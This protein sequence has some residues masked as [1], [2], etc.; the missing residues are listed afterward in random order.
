MLITFLD[1]ISGF[2][3]RRF[4]LA[5]WAPMFI[6][7]GLA[8]G[9][10]AS[11]LGW[12]RVVHWWTLLSGV[13]QVTLAVTTLLAET[14]LAYVLQAVAVPLVQ[15]Y[16]GYVFW[17]T[18][19]AAW[20]KEDQRRLRQ[21]L[22]DTQPQVSY[23][24]FPRG[25]DVMPTGLGNVFAAAEDYPRRMY[26]LDAVIWWPR[27][28]LSLPDDLRSQ[29]DGSVTAL[30]A[31]INLSA[32]LALWALGS[33]LLL[34][35]TDRR[36][37]LAGVFFGG[38]ALSWG[39]YQAA[40]TQAADYGN[41]MRVAFDLYRHKILEGMRIPVPDNLKAERALWETLTNWLLV[42]RPPWFTAGPS[43]GP[44][45]VFNAE[46]YP[47]YYDTHSMPQPQDTDVIVNGHPLL[48]IRR[49]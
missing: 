33:S 4:I 31:L 37:L 2:F 42:Y 46:N 34:L 22:D 12:G 28:T 20:G 32:L 43:G 7:A 24:R 30:Y 27:L 5:F 17:P 49:H 19:I 15:M 13:E 29:L 9:L 14:V 10:L 21:D 1:K 23:F 25:E 26:N 18:W 36:W 40:V 38:L 35:F 45:L 47:F 41:S 16:E 6:T 3:D 44:P 39:C 48:T 8:L 11:L